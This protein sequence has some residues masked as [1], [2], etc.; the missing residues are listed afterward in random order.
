VSLHPEVSVTI[1]VNVARSP[2]EAELQAQGINV[3]AEMF[4][5]EVAGFTEEFETDAEPGS[6]P[7]EAAAAEEAGGAEAPAGEDETGAA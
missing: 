1:R 6:V 2:E 4:E 3:M 7:A 5:R